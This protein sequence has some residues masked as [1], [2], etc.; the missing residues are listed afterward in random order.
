[1]KEG[2]QMKKAIAYVSDV[3]LGRSGEVISREYQKDLIKKHAETNGIEIVAWF[4]DE[5]YNENVLER[6][7]IKA[8]LA[9]AEPYDVVLT[10]RVWAFSRTMGVLETL[11]AELDRRGKTFEAATMLW[12]CTSQK[13]RR[14]FYP[15]LPKVSIVEK[16]VEE[17]NRNMKVAKPKK[18]FFTGL[19]KSNA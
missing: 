14:R 6:A 2:K 19:A 5:M 18:M 4:E 1:L 7:G 17:V 3:I 11:F 16:P 10:E 15:N 13:C 8:M 12:D 9:C